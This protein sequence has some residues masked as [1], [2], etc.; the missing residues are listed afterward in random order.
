M[1][2]RQRCYS[3][4]ST[5]TWSGGVVEQ[6]K[7][8]DP[9]TTEESDFYGPFTSL[10]VELFPSSEYYQVSPKFNRVGG[11]FD[12]TIQFIVLC[13]RVPVF[14]VEVKTF[15]SLKSLSTWDDADDQIRQRFCE[16]ASERHGR[17]T[18]P[19]WSQCFWHSVLR[20]RI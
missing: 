8:F 18:N 7:M 2:D 16:F 6:F 20:L 10:L 5:M 3:L 4:F 12:F 14:F 17:Y 13:R 19:L 15:H 9:N 11:S 1:I